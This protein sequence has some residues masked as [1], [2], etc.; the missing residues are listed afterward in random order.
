MFV[1]F[2][3]SQYLISNRKINKMDGFD[4][5]HIIFFNHSKITV[6]ELL[7]ISFSHDHLDKSVLAV[8]FHLL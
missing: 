7:I 2:N 4:R 8:R 1:N 6:S 5:A 3:S